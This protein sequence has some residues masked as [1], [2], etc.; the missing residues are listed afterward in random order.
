M[1]IT[2]KSEAKIH[3]SRKMAPPKH[4][5]PDRHVKRNPSLPLIYKFAAGGWK[6]TVEWKETIKGNEP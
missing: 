6:E 3:K 4:E 5:H 1:E 2:D